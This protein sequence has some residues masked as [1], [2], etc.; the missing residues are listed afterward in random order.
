MEPPGIKKPDP[1]QPDWYC[2]DVE[3]RAHAAGLAPGTRLDRYTLIRRFAMGGMAELYLAQQSGA[4]GFSKIVA[5][6]RILPHLAEDETFT[7]MFLAEARLASDLAH[8]NL[9]HVLDF[10][11][12]DG[13]HYLTM[14][15]VHGSNLLDVLNRAKHPLPLEAGLQIVI[16]V[17]RGLHDLHEHRAADGKTLGL[18]HRDVSPSNVLLSYDGSVK[19]TDFGIA[20]AMELTT[21]TRTGTF[22]GKLGHS[23]PEQARGEPVDRRSDVF[24]LGI[25]LYEVTTGARAFSGPNEFAVLGKVARAD[26]EPPANLVEDY[27]PELSDLVSHALCADPQGRPPDAAAFAEALAAFARTH[28]VAIGPTRVAALMRDLFGTPPP[29]A[30]PE[31]LDRVSTVRIP[32]MTRSAAM[33]DVSAPSRPW[34]AYALLPIALI[35]GAAGMWLLREP[36]ARP[37]IPMFVALSAKAFDPPP[38]AVADAN[39]P[40]PEPAADP[41]TQTHDPAPPPAS[42]E[43]KSRRGRKR[44][45]QPARRK[46]ETVKTIELDGALFPPEP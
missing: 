31:E 24:C 22:K 30:E 7:K 21:A 28:D 43:P 18:V 40:R 46:A 9:V 39:V 2:R 10:G 15:Y 23:S 25:L 44:A 1:R 45:R 32:A 34:V 35:L 16:E 6:K 20:K 33:T 29:V 5:L 3:I 4:A 26:Y 14:E 8:P 11:E 36:R 42:N 13:E 38:L 41:E 19:L 12:F 17:A 37:A 27:P